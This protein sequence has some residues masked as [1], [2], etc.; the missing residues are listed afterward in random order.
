M[1][2]GM[3]SPLPQ[4]QEQSGTV[5]VPPEGATNQ[6]LIAALTAAL[7]AGAS[8]VLI[9]KI[10]SRFPG[11]GSL[12]NRIV[13]DMGWGSLVQITST[14][15]AL[16]PRDLSPATQI[17]HE[18]ALRNALLRAVYLINASQ[19]L[20][21]FYRDE[22]Q[23]YQA[24]AVEEQ[25]RAAHE[26]AERK[27]NESAQQV[28]Q[29][30]AGYGVDKNGELLLGW[31]AVLDSRTSADCRWA[32]GRNFNALIRPSIGYPGTVHLSCR[33]RAGKPH[34]TRKRVERGTIPTHD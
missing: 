17:L 13:Q 27:R 34:A 32:N 4:P 19:R 33:C 23:L 7:V 5:T 6:Q 29:E 30:A 22:A 21:P 10:L 14:E 20:A 12:A 16:L 15:L 28:A 31:Y 18:T 11:V 26:E 9:S 25:Y 1:G 3:T 8:L 2:T 24:R